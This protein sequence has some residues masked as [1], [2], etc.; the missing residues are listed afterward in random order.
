MISMLGS[1]SLND[2]VDVAVKVEVL[3]RCD[4]VDVMYIAPDLGLELPLPLWLRPV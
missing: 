4:G 2:L 1:G 3:A